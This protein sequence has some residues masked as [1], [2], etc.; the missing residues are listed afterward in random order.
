MAA[1]LPLLATFAEGAAAVAAGSGLGAT[2]AGGIGAVTGAMAGSLGGFLTMGGGMLAGIGALTKDADLMKFGSIL[3]L[4]GGIGNLAAPSIFGKAGGAA[5]AGGEAASSAAE[6]SS[7]GV[8]PVAESASTGVGTQAGIGNIAKLEPLGSTQIPGMTP[9]PASPSLFERMGVNGGQSAAAPVPTGVAQAPGDSLWSK[10]LG[11]QS[12]V[13]TNPMD[14]TMGGAT[15]PGYQ[16][17]A[18][19]LAQ[20][21][22]TTTSGDLNSA[23]KAASDK[24]SSIVKGVPGFIKD[25]KEAISLAG[26]ALATMYGPQAE[27]LDWQKSLYERRRRNLNQPVR[28]GIVPP[29][30]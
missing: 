25:N 24:I 1:T 7:A 17:P 16:M 13:Q 22:S 26:N 11:G 21:A 6:A 18:D 28:L 19:P 14:P 8:G 27:A 9:A 29:G 12:L 2:I 10:A 30:G 3:T 15:V 20:F 23:L 4:A 5:A